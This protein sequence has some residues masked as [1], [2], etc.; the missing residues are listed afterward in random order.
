MVMDRIKVL[1]VEGGAGFTKI[2]SARVYKRRLETEARLRGGQSLEFVTNQI[3]DV[4]LMDLEISE[5]NNLEILRHVKQAN[6]EIQVIALAE[7]MSGVNKMAAYFYGAWAIL[8]KPVAFDSLF[9]TIV[10]AYR[11][12]HEKPGSVT[13]PSRKKPGKQT[14]SKPEKHS[15]TFFEPP[16]P[17]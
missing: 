9:E 16:E 10:S 2:I 17:S 7:Q 5:R 11:Y 8:E 4:I 13:R 15:N 14:F 12:R 6:P 1:V 3:P